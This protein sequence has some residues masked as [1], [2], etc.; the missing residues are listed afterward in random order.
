MNRPGPGQTLFAFVRHWSRRSAD[1]PRL[2]EAG[3]AVLVVEAVAALNHR[4]RPATVNAVAAEIGIDQSGAS[5]L[6]AGATASGYL[7]PTPDSADGR[8]RRVTVTPAGRRL[9]THA[10]RWQEQVFEQLTEDWSPRRRREFQQA[11]TDLL[12]RSYP[13]DD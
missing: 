5:R 10:H 2:A 8:R 4:D 12:E 3:R 6:V 13:A 11:M 7:A 9:L 1:D